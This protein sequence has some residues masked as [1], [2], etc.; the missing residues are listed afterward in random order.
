MDTFS[1]ATWNHRSVRCLLTCTASDDRLPAV[2][3]LF[4]V[5]VRLSGCFCLVC[6]AWG[7]L[8]LSICEILQV[9]KCWS[10]GF[11]TYFSAYLFLLGLQLYVYETL[12]AVSM[13]VRF[14]LFL[15]WN[16]SPI[17]L[18]RFEY[19]LILVFKFSLVFKFPGIFLQFSNCC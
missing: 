9:W 8:S 4:V 16:F 3:C 11:F 2:L 12:D 6:P 18:L 5:D 17:S 10:Q 1:S 7:L 15:C 13:S 14:C 19:F